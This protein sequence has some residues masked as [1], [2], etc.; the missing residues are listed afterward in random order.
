MKMVTQAFAGLRRA[1]RVAFKPGKPPI[2]TAI[3]KT[4]FYY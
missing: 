3:L 1:V 2:R 4:P